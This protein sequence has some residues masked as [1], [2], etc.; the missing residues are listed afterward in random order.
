[1]N[2]KHWHDLAEERV[3][4][5]QAL[6]V[7]HQWSSA[8]YLAGLCGGVCFEVVHTGTHRTHGRDIRGEEILRAVLDAQRIRA[9]VSGGVGRGTRR[10]RDRQSFVW[11]ELADR[12]EL[13][14]SKP[15]S[16]KV[17]I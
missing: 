1:M 2:R 5:A 11:Q 14:G 8:Y 3:M 10:F 6:L 17:A 13:D 9:R 4:A 15:I 16:T 7:A 12:S